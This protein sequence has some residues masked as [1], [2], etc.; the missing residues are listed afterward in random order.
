MRERTY[1]EGHNELG[2][3]TAGLDTRN[4]NCS[5]V[6]YTVQW[7]PGQN[8]RAMWTVALYAQGHTVF[9]VHANTRTNVYS[10]Q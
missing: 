9:C 5:Q 1:S 8:V 4:V 3:L 7:S 10:K 2:A 6:D